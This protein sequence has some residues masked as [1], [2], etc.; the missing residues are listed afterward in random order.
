MIAKSSTLTYRSW[1]CMRERC[2]N[3]NYPRYDNYGGRGIMVCPRWDSFDAFLADMGERPSKL[4]SI[5]RVDNSKGYS[6]DNCVWATR[7]QQS[8]N[9]RRN[10]MVIVDGVA[11]CVLDACRAVGMNLATFYKRRASLGMTDQEAIETAKGISP[12]P[13]SK[14]H[15]ARLT[16]ADVLQMR[17]A[18]QSGATSRELAARFAIHPK[19]AQRILARRM[20]KHI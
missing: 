14:N 13:G 18:H 6:P 3:P 20:W 9:T 17:A 16:E 4:H 10:R 2:N 12:A 5:E 1:T 8:R 11:M 15:F 19:T 7:H